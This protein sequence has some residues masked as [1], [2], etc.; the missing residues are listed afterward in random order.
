MV[1]GT[2]DALPSCMSLSRF[3][4]AVVVASESD[5]IAV[6]ARKMRDAHVGS[7]IVTRED[8]PIGIITD[9]DLAL[10][11][12]AEER[13]AT[14]TRVSD[15]V[16]YGVFTIKESDQIETAVRSMREHGVRRLPI[17]DDDGR[18]VGIVTADDLVVLLS[19]E[20]SGLADGVAENAD[21]YESR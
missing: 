4:R 15:V 13:N 12:V 9:R 7:I 10:R 19:K 21:A 17:V 14:T 8:R 16:T 18:I 3:A 20:F 5:P 11:I 2:A 1:D 6:V